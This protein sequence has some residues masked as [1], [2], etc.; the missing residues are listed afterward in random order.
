MV[1]DLHAHPCGASARPHPDGALSADLGAPA[2][3]DVG[4]RVLRPARSVWVSCDGAVGTPVGAGVASVNSGAGGADANSGAGAWLHGPSANGSGPLSGS[5]LSELTPG[6]MSAG[7]G[8]D[9]RPAV[10]TVA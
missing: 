8:G 2:V 10:R 6:I 9:R 7:L 5:L 1:A 4:R 3:V